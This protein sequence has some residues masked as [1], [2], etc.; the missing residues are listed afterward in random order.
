MLATTVF[1]GF[2]LNTYETAYASSYKQLDYV[3]SN[4]H[5]DIFNGQDYVPI[6]PMNSG[7]NATWH[8]NV[9]TGPLPQAP[10]YG[11]YAFD[12]LPGDILHEAFGARPLGIDFGHTAM[13]E[14]LFYDQQFGAFWR[15][16]ES[17]DDGR[18]NLIVMRSV[19][20]DYRFMS[21]FER[22]PNCNQSTGFD[23]HIL[24][25]PSATTAQRQ[26]AV[27]FMISQLGRPWHLQL[28]DR[29]LQSPVWMCST[30][31]WAA[32]A[33]QGVDI[34][35]GTGGVLPNDI[36]N[37]ANVNTILSYTNTLP[38]NNIIPIGQPFLSNH[39]I[40]TNASFRFTTVGRDFRFILRAPSNVVYNVIDPTG[41][42]VDTIRGGEWVE[43]R[44]VR[45]NDVIYFNRV[46]GSGNVTLSI[47]SWI[48]PWS[49]VPNHDDFSFSAWSDS[50]WPGPVHGGT[51]LIVHTVRFTPSFTGS[52]NFSMSRNWGNE[53][54]TPIIHVLDAWGSCSATSNSINAVF[55]LTA[56][57][58]YYIV[59]FT[60]DRALSNT[61]RSFTLN[62]SAN[63]F[64]FHPITGTE[65]ARVSLTQEG[66]NF[67]GRI[68]IPSH[69]MIG[70]NVYTITEI[71]QND[72]LGAICNEVVIPHTVA[73]IGYNAFPPTATVTWTNRYQFRGYIFLAYLGYSAN[74]TIPRYIAGRT[75]TQ[76]G[77]N[78][79]ENNNSVTF[80]FIPSSI[81]VIGYRAFANSAVRTVSFQHNSQLLAI[82][83]EAFIHTVFPSITL[84]YSV[85]IIGDRA[86]ARGDNSTNSLSVRLLRPANQVIV[87]LG[88]DVF[89][90]SLVEI[91][92]PT[93]ECATMYRRAFRWNDFRDYITSYSPWHL[94]YEFMSCQYFDVQVYIG[95]A[96]TIKVVLALGDAWGGCHEEIKVQIEG[97]GIDVWYYQFYWSDGG[98]V[99]A[100]MHIVFTISTTSSGVYL[101]FPMLIFSMKIGAN[102]RVYRLI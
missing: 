16:I 71:A 62:V 91:I 7:P 102:V 8:F 97:S 86:F 73:T 49:S 45:A 51:N 57:R 83:A 99:S 12:L 29:P 58:P 68:E 93:Q 14:G 18:G 38:P 88:I 53:A 32:Y 74:F 50:W 75:I 98:A 42:G 35:P 89:C 17:A 6:M 52:H 1:V 67:T 63:V 27:N 95:D 31:V 85:V 87:S 2:T 39:S 37:S 36:F 78:A 46:S 11:R 23:G 13:V 60:D 25:V 41:W 92:V 20:D 3:L 80:I 81:Q 22:P 34:A 77:S 96:N 54:L 40:S 5:E 21:R 33:N 69:T 19:L 26:A 15:I 76:I 55:N 84:P 101:E 90:S 48:Q 66:R 72:F 43:I 47:S 30:L 24:R 61:N 59:Y 70:G 94:V 28:G 100:E 82:G 10:V 44:G 79:F 4:T 9:G 65:N 56:N 64:Y